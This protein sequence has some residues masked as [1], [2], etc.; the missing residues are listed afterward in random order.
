MKLFKGD[1]ESFL[2]V[3]GMDPDTLAYV[4]PI[5]IGFCIE[6][7]IRT[8]FIYKTTLTE[9]P[10]FAQIQN[11][12]RIQVSIANIKRSSIVKSLIFDGSNRLRMM[13]RV[14]EVLK[15]CLSIDRE[16]LLNPYSWLMSSRRQAYRH[17]IWDCLYKK[18][19]RKSDS[20]G[21]NQRLS[22]FNIFART[23]FRSCLLGSEACKA[24]FLGHNVYH[25]RLL[26]DRVVEEDKPLVLVAAFALQ[27]V[28]TR[29]SPP[30]PL[31]T[32]QTFER[33]SLAT[34]EIEARNFWVKRFESA[35]VNM[36][37]D[38]YQ[39]SL[40][41]SRAIKS[42]PTDMVV[43]FL[44][45]FCDS[46]F[47]WLD[48][49][50]P[51]ADYYSWITE[52]VRWSEETNTRV[53][54][55][56]HPSHEV[57]GENS[58]EILFRMC[59]TLSKSKNVVID[60]KQKFSHSDILKFARQIVTFKGTVHME[61]VASGFKPIVLS[62]CMMSYHFPNSVLKPKTVHEYHDLLGKKRLAVTDELSME[63]M[64]ILFF[65]EKFSGLKQNIGAPTLYREDSRDKRMAAS[66]AIVEF[67]LEKQGELMRMGSKLG[68]RQI[69][70]LTTL[71]CV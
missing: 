13:V 57:W 9:I 18:Y 11:R 48:S 53:L 61:A 30:P 8:I 15:D 35:Q 20:F 28:P 2:F 32:R 33:L 23:L 65:K 46:P 1:I 25:M 36:D 19:G 47:G 60:W 3:D 12:Y 37:G 70:S 68:R 24:A 54:L 55:R 62:E 56:F 69:D 21:I 10:G 50:R 14:L 58:R 16:D 43:L 7:D 45:V 71:D 22:V 42:F 44:P 49:E 67:S 59:P 34:T 27:I 17:G 6:A 41:E 39:L 51:F 40:A 38:L 4:L 66:K 63:A 26:A 64:K 29:F 5:M 31:L 52:T